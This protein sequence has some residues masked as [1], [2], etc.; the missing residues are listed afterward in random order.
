[1]IRERFAIKLNNELIPPKIVD[2]RD[3]MDNVNDLYIQQDFTFVPFTD[4]KITENSDTLFVFDFPFQK[5]HIK[6]VKN[7]NGLTYKE[8]FE[9]VYDMFFAIVSE[10]SKYRVGISTLGCDVN[11]IIINNIYRINE[12]EF[13]IDLC[14]C[15]DVLC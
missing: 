13:H 12:K 4:Q 2:C 8:F 9:H 3:I 14:Q 5:R 6:H 11:D 15:D 7:D 10:Y 1:M